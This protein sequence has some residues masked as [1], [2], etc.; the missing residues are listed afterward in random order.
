[1]SIQLSSRPRRVAPGRRRLVDGEVR[2]RFVIRWSVG[3]ALAIVLVGGSTFVSATA[4]ASPGDRIAAH[5]LGTGYH[6]VFM[7][8]ESDDSYALHGSSLFYELFV[9]RRWGF[10]LRFSAYLP[11]AGQM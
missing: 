9:G 6:A 8:T 2:G 5:S 11:V 3:V 1:M 7:R 4:L 10:M